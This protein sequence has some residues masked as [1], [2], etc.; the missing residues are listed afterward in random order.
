MARIEEPFR[1][2]II[3]GAK[4]RV[5]GAVEIKFDGVRYWRYISVHGDDP[6]LRTA[7]TELIRSAM[8]D[9]YRE[10]PLLEPYRRW[11]WHEWAE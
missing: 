3:K 11:H 2:I 7:Y 4:D 5:E 10:L 6:N 8:H 1:H 9:I